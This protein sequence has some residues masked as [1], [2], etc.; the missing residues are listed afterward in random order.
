MNPRGFADVRCNNFTAPV[1]VSFLLASDTASVRV[2]SLGQM[3]AN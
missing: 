3:V 1:T 2:F